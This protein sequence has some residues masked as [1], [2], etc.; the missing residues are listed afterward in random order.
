MGSAG[1]GRTGSGYAATGCP[2]GAQ[3][4]KI[5]PFKPGAYSD[6]GDGQHSDHSAADRSESAAGHQSND[7]V[8]ALMAR[9]AVDS[10][11]AEP[12]QLVAWSAADQRLWPDGAVGGD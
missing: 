1:P 5:T 8:S 11:W 9:P 6:A 2:A 7:A 12:G 3:S 10:A 4:A